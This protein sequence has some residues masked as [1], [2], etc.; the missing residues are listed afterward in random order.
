MLS[1]NSVRKPSLHGQTQEK[2]PSIEDDLVNH[3]IRHKQLL[4]LNIPSLNDFHLTLFPVQVETDPLQH[5]TI[6]KNLSTLLRESDDSCLNRSSQAK[7]SL[8]TSP[9]A[10]K[11]CKDL[12]LSRIK[13]ASSK[14][15][16]DCLF[17]ISSKSIKL[18]VNKFKKIQYEQ[19]RRFKLIK[20]FMKIIGRISNNRRKSG[21]KALARTK[22]DIKRM[23]T[24]KED[25][26]LHDTIKFKYS[27]DLIETTKKFN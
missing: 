8:A 5:S 9:Q 19:C 25:R 1:T 20:R 26:E 7:N 23:S 2:M 3:L 16:D 27:P 12:N 24:I 11:L 13:E 14:V 10:Q 4:K 18:S 22:S 15:K 6:S 21:L 17:P